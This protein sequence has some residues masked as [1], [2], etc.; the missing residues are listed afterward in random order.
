[1]K[2]QEAVEAGWK[3]LTGKGSTE[4]GIGAATASLIQA[5][6]TDSRRVLPC[7]WQ[8]KKDENSPVIYTSIPS[9][10]GAGGVIGRIAPALS[11]EEA[12]RFDESCRLM[13]KYKAEY[14]DIRQ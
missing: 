1:M 6:L 14:L 11:K 7:S 5:I 12:K 8:Y 3:I 4:Y 9:V 13:E 2:L 10:I